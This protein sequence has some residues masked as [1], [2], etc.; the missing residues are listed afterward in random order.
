ML[1][2][3]A[4]VTATTSQVE[5]GDDLS[6]GTRTGAWVD[7]IDLSV[8]D[9][10][11]AIPSIKDGTID[12][13]A[14]G[15]ST[16]LS[17]S[18]LNDPSIDLV[19]EKELYYD[20]TMNPAVFTDTSK[21]NPFAVPKV[22]EAMNWLIDREYLNQSIFNDLSLEKF[23]PLATGG[24]DYIRLSE[25]VNELEAYYAYNP[26]LAESTIATEMLA[27]G[28]TK[29]A[30]QWYFAGEPVTII[31]L[32]RND[33][34]GLRIPMGDYVADQ[35]ESIGF[36][37]DRLYMTSSEASPIWIGGDPADGLFHIYTGAWWDEN[38]IKTDEGDNFN[39]FYSP[40]GVYGFSSLW[41]ANAITQEFRDLC[42]QLEYHQ[43]DTLEEFYQGYERALELALENSFHIWLIDG[44]LFL[45]RKATTTAAFDVVAGE[46]TPLW[47]HT[48]RFLEAEGGVMR[49]GVPDM[50]VDPWNPIAG[51]YESFDDFAINATQESGLVIDPYSGLPIPQRIESAEV[52][53]QTGL[54][55]RDSSDWLTLNF[56][57][58]IQVPVDAWVDWDASAQEFITRADAYPSGLTA[59]IKS[60]VTYPDDLFDTVTW[61]D[62]SPLDMADFVM[63][64]IMTFDRGKPNSAIYDESYL[65]DYDYFMSSF[66]GVRI[67]STNPLI[68]ETY[69]DSNILDAEF[70][71]STWWPEADYGP[72]PWHTTALAALAEANGLLAFSWDKAD[73]LSRQ[74]TNYIY[75]SSLTILDNQLSAVI[76]INFIPY[77]PTLGAYITTG[78]ASTRWTNLNTWY[79]TYGHFWLGTGP[80][81]V[82]S[83][84][85]AGKTLSL[86]RFEAYP[87]ESGRWDEYS[88][89]SAH[90]LALDYSEGA[91]GSTFTIIGSGY[92]ANSLATVYI[93]YIGVGTLM[94]DSDGKFKLTIT[95]S[96]ATQAGDYLI[97]VSVN[98]TYS[99]M[100]Q[101]D[102]A[103]PLR[104]HEELSDHIDSPIIGPSIQ[105]FLPMILK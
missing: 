57:N 26:S 93:N 47:A 64:M 16:S 83:L 58:F 43:F 99:V 92:P 52:T 36:Q 9:A 27:L 25:T 88:Q 56:T 77:L 74:W 97:T 21:L 30:D 73:A 37:T 76:P 44:R 82:E 63:N 28:A 42:N 10:S 70:S 48:A 4:P 7:T 34:D 39:V 59:S 78:E 18:S 79:D 1:F 40:D 12:M 81:F 94:T 100:I 24:P 22:R 89:I 46:L 23:F 75:G 29:V 33:S 3:Y 53:A 15:L 91:P 65:G 51:S 14:D 35:L 98:P 86:Q 50:F 17:A 68:I 103:S 2:Q 62:G 45:P 101:I 49:V 11:Q 54:L 60:V 84:N 5:V 20:L 105:V 8:I 71:V 6:R 95:M 67:I 38:V 96:I 80:F 55:M 87:D 31:L 104:E 32:I 13:Y 41:Q 85:W 72:T 69:L 61:H 90:N 102:P 66:K 19:S